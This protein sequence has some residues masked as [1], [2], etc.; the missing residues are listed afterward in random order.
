[1]KMNNARIL[2]DLYN[3]EKEN[4]KKKKV[5]FTVTGLSKGRDTWAL[6]WKMA[7]S[8]ILADIQRNY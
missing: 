2:F 1:M 3:K 7:L 5:W 8:C 6:T 4:E